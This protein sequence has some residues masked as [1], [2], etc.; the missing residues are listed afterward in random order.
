MAKLELTAK[1]SSFLA[2]M[3]LRSSKEGKEYAAKY[4]CDP[5]DACGPSSCSDC[6]A[7]AEDGIKSGLNPFK[8]YKLN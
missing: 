3:N 5:C 6:K 8:G 1:E 2:S 4:G 7:C